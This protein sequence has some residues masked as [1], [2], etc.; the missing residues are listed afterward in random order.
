MLKILSAVFI[1]WFGCGL[2]SNLLCIIID[3]FRGIKF[4]KHNW[5][6]MIGQ[7]FLGPLS[8]LTLAYIF[9]VWKK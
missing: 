1:F 9:F 7:L 5:T 2:L 6:I 8:L 3:L 4:R